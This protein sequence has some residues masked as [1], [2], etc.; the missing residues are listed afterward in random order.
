MSLSFWGSGL[1]SSI[2][3]SNLLGCSS[4]WRGQ[5]ALFLR[6]KLCRKS[7]NNLICNLKEYPQ[8]IN[9]NFCLSQSEH[10][11]I[12]HQ[13]LHVFCWIGI[14]IHSNLVLKQLQHLTGGTQVVNNRARVWSRYICFTICM[15]NYL[16]VQPSP[17]VKAAL[18]HL[19]TCV[20][21]WVGEAEV[22]WQGWD[23]GLKDAGLRD[24]GLRGVG[25]NDGSRD[26][27]LKD[28]AT[29]C[30]SL[31]APEF[32]ARSDWLLYLPIHYLSTTPQAVL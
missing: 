6:L 5:Q 22:R 30:F 8:I 16:A 1:I 28:P 2:L 11:T 21:T 29:H 26:D 24:A 10:S 32:E 25:L 31:L 9:N 4:I 19:V 20:G 27:G 13:M 15:A 18:N 23:A 14:F 7:D 3:V 12:P 17:E